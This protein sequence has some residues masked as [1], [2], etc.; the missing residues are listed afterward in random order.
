[1]SEAELSRD[2]QLYCGA[3]VAAA[4]VQRSSWRWRSASQPRAH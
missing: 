3:Y 1:M 2:G 4:R